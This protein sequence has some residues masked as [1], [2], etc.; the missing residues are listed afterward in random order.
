MS[1]TSDDGWLYASVSR[2]LLSLVSQSEPVHPEWAWKC[3]EVRWPLALLRGEMRAYPNKLIS[4]ISA[5]FPP[6]DPRSA[7]KVW[8]HTMVTWM[9]T[10]R[11]LEGWWAAATEHHGYGIMRRVLLYGNHSSSHEIYAN[12]WD[13]IASDSWY[14]M[15]SPWLYLHFNPLG[16]SI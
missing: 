9:M 5:R 13:S 14:Y 6:M 16:L 15:F 1:Q 3:L 7:P 8:L 2:I 4:T 10:R 11:A 12:V